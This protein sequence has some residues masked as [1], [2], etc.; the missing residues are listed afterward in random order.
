DVITGTIKANF[1][2]RISFQ[3]T[4]KIDSRTILGEQGAEQLLGMGDMLYMAGGGRIQRVH[5]P[6]VADDEVEKV[7]NHLKTQGVPE[8]LDA[9]TE[10]D[11]EDGGAG[12]GGGM[13]PE[14]G[15]AESNDIYD[16]AVAVVLRDR[17][18]STSYVQ[19]RLGIGYNRAASLI[20]RMEKEGLISP[21]NSSG[22]RDILVP[23]EDETI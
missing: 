18:V 16:Q 14:G 8:Y 1:P 11:E 21:A 13:G 19:R 12:M 2:T 17:K 15:L 10:E 3:V 5:G 23:G 20:E 6:F 7:V 9:V 4:S 22:K